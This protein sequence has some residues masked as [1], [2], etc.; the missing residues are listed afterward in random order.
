MKKVKKETKINSNDFFK[1][2]SDWEQK[3]NIYFGEKAPQLPE[4]ISKF[5][6]KVN[7]YFMIVGLILTIPAILFAFG[8]GALISPLAFLN[9]RYSVHFSLTTIFSL[10]ILVLDAMAIPGL[11]KRQ[12]SAWNLIFYA[13]LVQ[14]LSY[15]LNFN[16]GSLVVGMAISWY[17]LFQIRKEYK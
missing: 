2:L 9:L 15:L 16:L 13:S 6:V 1:M 3:L 12:K 11:F 5:I 7:P 4:N 14:A 8:L 17:F 10:I